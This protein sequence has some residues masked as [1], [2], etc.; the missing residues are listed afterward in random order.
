MV[1]IYMYILHR[2]EHLSI[3]SQVYIQVS[4]GWHVHHCLKHFF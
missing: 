1:Q 3:G 4:I 2:S